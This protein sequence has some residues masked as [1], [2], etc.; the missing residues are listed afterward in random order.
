MQKKISYK[1]C[2]T[3]LLRNVFFKYVPID[4]THILY[5]KEKTFKWFLWGSQGVLKNHWYPKIIS[6]RV[7]INFFYNRKKSESILYWVLWS[8]VKL[9][10]WTKNYRG[11]RK[12]SIYNIY[13]IYILFITYLFSANVEHSI[14]CLGSAIFHYLII[15]H[16][17]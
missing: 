7:C 6:A 16:E 3:I 8:E 11:V 10:F 1:L 15:H 9:N 4:I 5:L 17:M 14:V 12:K 13:I 2:W